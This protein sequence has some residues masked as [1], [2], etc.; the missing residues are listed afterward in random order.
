M[1]VDASTVSVKRLS[2]NKVVTLTINESGKVTDV[3]AV[4]VLPLDNAE[5]SV[6]EGGTFK[7]PKKHTAS[8]PWTHED[9]CHDRNERTGKQK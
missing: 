2:D 1:R 8:F 6:L 5:Y 3:E 4:V 9:V 7:V